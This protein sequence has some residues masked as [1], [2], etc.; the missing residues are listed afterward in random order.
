MTT[1]KE[2][3]LQAFLSLAWYEVF[4]RFIATF[5]AKTSELLLAAGLVVSSANFLTDG[6]VL[7]NGNFASNAWAW[8]QAIAIDSSLAIS[9][10]NALQCMKQ[11]DWTKCILYSLLTL[12]LALVAGAVTNIDIYSHAIHTTIGT[13]MSKIGIDVGVLSTLRA[14]AV[15]GFVLMSRLRDVSLK[16]LYVSDGA[17]SQKQSDEASL[18]PSEIKGGHRFTVEEVAMLARIFSQNGTTTVKEVSEAPLPHPVSEG[19]KELPRVQP[20]FHQAIDQHS[21][22]ANA[23][24]ESVSQQT[25]PLS[26]QQ[27]ETASDTGIPVRPMQGEEPEQLQQDA[28]RY[29]EAPHNDLHKD[30]RDIPRGTRVHKPTSLSFDEIEL[31]EPSPEQEA[32]LEKA[33]Q[34]LRA[35]RKKLSGRALAKRAHIHRSTC[36]TW[37]NAHKPEELLSERIVPPD[38]TDE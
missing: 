9:F 28:P 36:S 32:R 18:I 2:Q 31:G 4:L 5:I 20:S 37:L 33:Y 7:H 24:D 12:L 35:E 1:K 15:V 21:R 11:R 3:R 25:P 8:T 29:G 14:I 22:S 19:K 30:L 23:P 13:T 16:E 34:E 38:D 6:A 26:V 17:V 27:E 10:Y